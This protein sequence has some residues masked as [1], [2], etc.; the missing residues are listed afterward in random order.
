MLINIPSKKK[1]AD[2]FLGRQNHLQL[3]QFDWAAANNYK[4][5][6]LGAKEDKKCQISD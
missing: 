3:A 6:L 1:V 5:L 2:I 4:T